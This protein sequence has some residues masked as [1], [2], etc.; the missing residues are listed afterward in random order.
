M[1]F[2]GKNSKDIRY[3]EIK[4]VAESLRKDFKKVGAIGFCWGEFP[5]S[6]SLFLSKSMN[7]IRQNNEKLTKKIQADGQ[8]SSSAQRA[9]TSSTASPPPT[10]RC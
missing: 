10:L 7:H 9:P 1:G 3:P 5:P 8:S 6:S 2:L 4:A